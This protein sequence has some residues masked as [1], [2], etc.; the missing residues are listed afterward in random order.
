VTVRCIECEE[1]ELARVRDRRPGQTLPIP[2][3]AL[4]GFPMGRT[5]LDLTRRR[6]LQWGVAGFASVYAAQELVWENVWESVAEAAE[7]PDQNCLVLLYLA[8]G[9]DGLNVVVPNGAGAISARS[10]TTTRTRTRG[11]R[12]SAPS[13]TRGRSPARATRPSS[14]S[15]TSPSRAPPTTATRT[16]SASTRSTATAAAARGQTSP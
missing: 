3:A 15:P 1:I 7:A 9:N 6:L 4:D 13:P 12:S 16:G 2:N 11:R 10:T 8:G 5:R 14:R